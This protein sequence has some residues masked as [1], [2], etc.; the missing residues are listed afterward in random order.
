MPRPR[1]F[2]RA[3]RR[4]VRAGDG[5]PREGSIINISSMAARLGALPAVRPT[6][7]PR[8]PGL[9]DARMDR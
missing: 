8:L 1:Q 7:P 5:S 2:L 6:G 4:G 9:L 3:R